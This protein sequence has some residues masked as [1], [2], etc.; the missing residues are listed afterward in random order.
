MIETFSNTRWPNMIIS[1]ANDK[2]FGHSGITRFSPEEIDRRRGL[3]SQALKEHDCDLFI[4]QGWFP[5]ATMGC[6]SGM[7]W[8]TGKHHHR[9]TMTIIV[10]FPP[11][12]RKTK[13]MVKLWKTRIQSN[14]AR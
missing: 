3:L 2:P 7:Y 12:D 1:L 4:T 9:N 11:I 6:F 14:C 13:G 10:T 8:L 5:T